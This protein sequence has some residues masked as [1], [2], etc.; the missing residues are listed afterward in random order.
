MVLHSPGLV[1]WDIHV[2]IP[3]L[4]R[5]SR[6]NIHKSYETNSVKA[7]HSTSNQKFSGTRASNV[8]NMFMQWR[9]RDSFT[10]WLNDSFLQCLLEPELIVIFSFFCTTNYV[11]RLR[12][13]IAQYFEMRERIVVFIVYCY[14]ECFMQHRHQEI[15]LPP[16]KTR[17]GIPFCH[18]GPRLNIT[19][20]LSMYGD[21]H[22]ED[23]TAVRTSYL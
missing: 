2:I 23:K 21:S 18:P 19:T 5:G 17:R 16:T 1:Q 6:V 4:V 8:E 14:K 3:L 13:K 9:H 10:Y 20:V 22:V 15:S 12:R 11:M 7:F